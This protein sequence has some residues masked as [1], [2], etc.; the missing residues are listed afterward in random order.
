MS[1]TKTELRAI[2]REMLRLMDRA[3]YLLGRI[4]NQVDL[5]GIT[6]THTKHM[7]II[8][9][10]V[11]T[12]FGVPQRM[13]YSRDRHEAVAR[14][15]Q[16]CM[17]LGRERLKLSSP[18]IGKMFRRDHGTV[19]AAEKTIANLVETNAVF[20]RDFAEVIASIERELKPST[21]P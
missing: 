21:I 14:A 13:I 4:N 11:C 16:V 17:V 9:D 8:V 7:E 3:D 15:R 1:D 20:R 2:G 6:P 12:K 5:T 19:L 18:Q 10:V